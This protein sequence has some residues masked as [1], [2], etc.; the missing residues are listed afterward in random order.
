MP[1]YSPLRYP[2]GKNCIFNFVSGLLK[3]NNLC[4]IKYAEP[5]AGGAG[6][7]LRLLFEEF[8]EHIYINDLD[9]AL[10]SFWV[11]VVTNADSFCAWIADVEVSVDVWRYYKDIYEKGVDD[12]FETAKATFY[13]NR[14]NVSGVLKGGVIGGLEQ[15][16]KY[17]IDARFNKDDLI[18]R[19][20]KI[21]RYRGRITVS[22]AD[23]I[24]FLMD[25]DNRLDDVFV[26]IDPPYFQ[27]GSEL[28]MNYY[29]TEDHERLMDRIKGL[30]NLWMLS[31]DNNDYVHS[32]YGEWRRIIYRLSQS[33]SNRVGDEVLI[34][35]N[36]LQF[37]N[38]IESLTSPCLI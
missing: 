38:S 28:Y 37:F 10:Y 33:A 29:L 30:W 31:Y 7:A 4:G 2:G 14:T 20:Q 8:V 25:I 21:Y 24:D 22:N 13:L 9:R 18:S 19:I 26:Y 23:G 5:Y 35:S 15:S 11:S 1:F 32:L 17:K 6:L 16:G 34:F 3:E 27:K 12:D 36:D